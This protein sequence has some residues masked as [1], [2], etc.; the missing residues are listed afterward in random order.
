[1]SDVKLSFGSDEY[2]KRKNTLLKD[3]NQTLSQRIS[4]S[5]NTEYDCI[6]SV[7]GGKDSYYQT[8]YVIN[9]LKLKPLLVTYNGNNYTDVGWK[10]S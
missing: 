1:M 4:H 2:L 5:S 10:I 7:S 6:V 8:H 9:E 3:I